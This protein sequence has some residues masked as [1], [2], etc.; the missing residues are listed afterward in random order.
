MT[1]QKKDDNDKD[2]KETRPEEG[3]NGSCKINHFKDSFSHKK[4][5]I[6]KSNWK[7]KWPEYLPIICLESPLRVIR[8]R[9]TA[10][11]RK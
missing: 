5:K 6:N 8:N 9:A 4:T 7:L 1:Y 11:N 10:R 3:H 2:I